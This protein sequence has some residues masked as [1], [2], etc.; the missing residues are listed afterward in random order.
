MDLIVPSITGKIMLEI[1]RRTETL[2]SRRHKTAHETWKQAPDIYKEVEQGLTD[3][4]T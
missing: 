2:I 1:Q 3:T 4:V